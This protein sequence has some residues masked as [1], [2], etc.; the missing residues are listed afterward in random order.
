MSIHDF[1]DIEIKARMASKALVDAMEVIKHKRPSRLEKNPKMSSKGFI[2]RKQEAGMK[3]QLNGSKASN[4]LQNESINKSQNTSFMQGTLCN[5][6]GSPDIGPKVQKSNV[7]SLKR[8]LKGSRLNIT[9]NSSLKVSDSSKVYAKAIG[10]SKDSSGLL[11]AQ[12]SDKNLS[13]GEP[14]SPIATKG[15]LRSLSKPSILINNIS[16]SRS[17]AGSPN[18]SKDARVLKNTKK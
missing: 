4:Y 18:S 11:G 1:L 13:F 8:I 12:N 2:V 17:I 10:K 5:D 15:K 3:S 16:M 7:I 14:V 9:V 6:D